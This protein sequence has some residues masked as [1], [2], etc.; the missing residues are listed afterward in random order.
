ME[1]VGG[2]EGDDWHNDPALEMAARM[3][4]AALNGDLDG[5]QAAIESGA[6]IGAM[7][8]DGNTALHL[9]VKAGYMDLVE[10][11][12]VRG[13]DIN[14]PNDEGDTPLLLTVC[15][16]ALSLRPCTLR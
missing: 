15:W 9:A 10:A 4:G 7:D 1:D 16:Y 12:I 14:A 3:L 13:L 6:D 2:E 8:E 11:L 5:M